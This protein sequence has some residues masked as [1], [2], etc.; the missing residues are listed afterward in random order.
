MRN[1]T[2]F[3]APEKGNKMELASSIHIKETQMDAAIKRTAEI[4]AKRLRE[5]VAKF[6]LNNKKFR[7]DDMGVDIYV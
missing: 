4:R 7:L 6:N 5:E 2:P 1:R 3:P